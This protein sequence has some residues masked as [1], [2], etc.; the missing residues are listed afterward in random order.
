MYT[1]IY[2]LYEQLI[3]QSVTTS[4]HNLEEPR[5]KCNPTKK[6]ITIITKIVTIIRLVLFNLRCTQLGNIRVTAREIE[7]QII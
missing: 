1:K 7:P 6:L 5:K 4:Q 3:L 2:Q